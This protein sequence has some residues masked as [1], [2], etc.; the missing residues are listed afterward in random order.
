MRRRKRLRIWVTVG[1]LGLAL[2]VVILVNSVC[3]C[4]RTVY[5]EIDLAAVP[6]QAMEKARSL[7]PGLNFHRA[8]KFAPESVVSRKEFTGYL[9]RGGG[10]WYNSRDIEVNHWDVKLAPE[11]LEP[12]K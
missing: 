8:W 6:A 11:H 10:H 3:S 2:T 1:A 12:I 5:Q 9:L 4:D 7:A